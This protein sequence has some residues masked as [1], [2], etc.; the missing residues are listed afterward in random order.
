MS[1]AE[2]PA[3]PTNAA[4]KANDVNAAE[5]IANPFPVAA[6]VFPTASKLSV[7]SRTSGGS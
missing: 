1:I 7:R 3:T 6:V 4:N 5:A 2:I